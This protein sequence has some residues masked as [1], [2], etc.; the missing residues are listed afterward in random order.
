MSQHLVFC[1]V[2]KNIK[3]VDIYPLWPNMQVKQSM[4]LLQRMADVKI[5]NKFK[6]DSRLLLCKI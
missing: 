3:L 4:S 6:L 1:D 2:R 5:C